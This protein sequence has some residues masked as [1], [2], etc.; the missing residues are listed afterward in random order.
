MPQSTSNKSTKQLSKSEAG[1]VIETMQRGMDYKPI[2]AVLKACKRGDL[3][4]AI[5]DLDAVLKNNPKDVRALHLKNCI[6]EGEDQLKKGIELIRS[7]INEDDSQ[8][9]AM[10]SLGKI[11]IN[12]SDYVNA[13]GAIEEST[14]INQNYPQAWFYLGVT[15]LQ[16]AEAIKAIDAYRIA[17]KIKPNF[18][19][20][21]FNLGNALKAQGELREAI[22]CYQRV[23]EIKPDCVEGHLNLG[24]ALNQSS[25]HK[26]A[27]I[28]FNKA[29]EL[30]PDSSKA[31]LLLGNTLML[32]G[33]NQEAI[34]VYLKAIS[35][36]PNASNAYS[37]M[38]IA[39][40]NLLKTNKAIECFRKAIELDPDK[41]EVYFNLG[42]TLKRIGL[43]KEAR[44][45]L[46]KAI[47]LK[48]D[49]SAAYTALGNTF[50]IP[51]QA[52]T[53]MD[54][55]RKAI[56]SNP[57]S[58]E[59]H[60]CLGN[61]LKELGDKVDA[62]NCFQVALQIKPDLVEA[63]LGM[64][65]VLS[66][67]GLP[68]DSN[69]A[70][71]NYLNHKP[72]ENICS[73]HKSRSETSSPQ[74]EKIQGLYVP[75]NAEF[76]PSYVSNIDFLGMHMMHLHIPK[77]GG[78][79]FGL[80]IM[81][82]IKSWYID[83]GLNNH[84]ELAQHLYRYDDLGFLFWDGDN[85]AINSNQIIGSLKSKAARRIDFTFLQPHM[86]SHKE[87]HTF[88]K[89][90]YEI[91]PIRLAIY[92]EPQQRLKSALNHL[93]RTS[94]GNIEMVKAKINQRDG[95]LDNPI[96]RACYSDFNKVIDDQS[97]LKPE[98]DSLLQISDFSKL[99]EIQSLFLSANILPNIIT[100]K[101]I[102]TS[103]KKDALSSKSMATLVRQCVES[104]FIEHDTSEN[105]TK[106]ITE[107]IA[108]KYYPK[109]Y[110]TQKQ[111]HPLTYILK[112]H[113]GDNFNR[114]G[115]IVE[116]RF[117]KTSQGQGFLEDVFTKPIL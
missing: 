80:P 35:I 15:Q 89:K 33:K 104:G 111:V 65:E 55:F 44:I 13:K 84:K 69:I 97:N 106:L 72:I 36:S 40:D 67:Q 101:Y 115:C 1:S 100:D 39:L 79:R 51:S 7:T 60:Y 52:E 103:N 10:L 81:E 50:N 17:I 85:V 46:R 105:V 71:A 27:L 22:S 58:A 62:Q 86:V 95:F 29:I 42:N 76:I 88:L 25:K 23:V 96:Y 74:S 94:A 77:A 5:E 30:Q 110:E 28:S 4:R 45:Y 37:N 14:K 41:S 64:A 109:C 73:I 9:L 91:S 18:W 117:L 20:A 87:I 8:H 93:W 26:E 54:N 21:Y 113:T 12:S 3:T 63:Y 78:T 66:D 107:N 48:T 24:L 34:E 83:N 6:A 49:F 16:I 53:A 92:R 70:Y 82:C 32:E 2:E 11:F 61:R 114:A 56:K 90:K 47:K 116:T 19:E 99:S 98:V 102:H 38:G 108:N 112:T 31:Y 43:N 68:K 57:K 75:N 59:A